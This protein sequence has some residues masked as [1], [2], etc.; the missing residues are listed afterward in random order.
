MTLAALMEKLRAR[1]VT[2][3]AVNGQVQVRGWRRLTADE[4]QT[5]RAAKDQVRALL[6]APVKTGK[7]AAPTVRTR[8]GKHRTPQVPKVRVVVGQRLVQIGGG[9]QERILEPV[10]ADEGD[11]AWLASFKAA[12]CE[13]RVRRSSPSRY[14]RARAICADVGT[15]VIVRSV[16]Q[17]WRNC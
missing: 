7:P 10:Y 13:E 12:V 3:V 16:R 15:D 4:R 6:T 2:F 1:G 9:Y 14:L 8:G 5:L 17:R 11:R